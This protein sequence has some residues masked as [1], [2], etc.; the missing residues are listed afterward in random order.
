MGSHR[1]R[2]QPKVGAPRVPVATPAQP[3][4]TPSTPSSLCPLRLLCLLC[5]GGV[6]VDPREP[7]CYTEQPPWS[8]YRAPSFGFGMLVSGG[9]LLCCPLCFFLRFFLGS[10]AAVCCAW[11]QPPHGRGHP[12][13]G[14]VASTPTPT[15]AGTADPGERHLCDLGVVPQPGSKHHPGQHR[16]PAHHGPRGSLRDRKSVV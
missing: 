13:L 11:G 10:W 7:F 6:Y 5:T 4:S 9:S 8:D 3:T 16:H 14:V 2:T 12:G 15:S 1:G